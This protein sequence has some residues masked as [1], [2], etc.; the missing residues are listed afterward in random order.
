MWR[1][2][3]ADL[4]DYPERAYAQTKARIEAGQPGDG[5]PAED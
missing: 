3:E 5:E 1:V 2:S 4:A